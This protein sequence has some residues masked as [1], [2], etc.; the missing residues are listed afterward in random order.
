MERSK[1]KIFINIFFILLTILFIFPLI[2]I[3]SI[4]FT[5]E[6]S[7][8]KYGFTMIPS[9]VSTEA[10]QFVFQDASGVFHAYLV[11]IFVT[12]AGSILSLLVTSM[13][14]YAVSRKDFLLA[15]YI[16]RYVL[17]V[18]LFNGGLVT[19]YMLIVNYL[20]LKNSI[21]VMILPYLV[22]PMHVFLMRSFMSELPLAVFESAKIDGAGE[23]RIFINILIPLSK[24]AFATIGLFSAF[25]YWNDWFLSLMFIDKQSLVPIQLMLY[26][27][28]QSAENVVKS[29]TTVNVNTPAPPSEQV[30]MA[31][32]LL[33]VGPIMIVFPFFQKYF[34]KGLTLG[35][36]KG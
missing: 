19:W 25:I 14:A 32:C 18:L 22:P 1:S 29:L 23:I 21:W 33:A 15:K 13:L 34:I 7:L 24:P 20:H 10:F 6:N 26:R 35:S 5:S 12:V 28:M 36:I 3:V 8:L 30:R 27:V 31:V 17:F 4:S 2:F 16:T 11:S 9:E